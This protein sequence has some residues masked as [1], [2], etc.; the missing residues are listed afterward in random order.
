M[1]LKVRSTMEVRQ[2]KELYRERAG[3]L[4]AGS[5][6]MC[7]TKYLQDRETGKYGIQEGSTLN[8]VSR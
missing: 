2:V 5:Y 7:G 1:T 3:P 8:F 6:L 4:P